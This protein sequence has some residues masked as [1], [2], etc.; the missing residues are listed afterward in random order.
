MGQLIIIP[1]VQAG[2]IGTIIGEDVIAY[3][4]FEEIDNLKIIKDCKH[5]F[6]GETAIDSRVEG[7]LLQGLPVIKTGTKNFEVNKVQD[8]IPATKKFSV[9]LWFNLS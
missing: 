3:Y 8:E 5:N 1:Q 9:E 7:Y 4:P 6:Y 2:A